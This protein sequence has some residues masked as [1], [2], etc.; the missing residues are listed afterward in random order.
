MGEI[1][2]NYGFHEKL[3]KSA[4][5]SSAARAQVRALNVLKVRNGRENENLFNPELLWDI[6]WNLSLTISRIM[7]MDFHR[8]GI[9]LA[10][11]YQ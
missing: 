7:K 10:L 4:I 11:F 3:D 5:K 9:R 8:C 2:Q 6:L 1:I